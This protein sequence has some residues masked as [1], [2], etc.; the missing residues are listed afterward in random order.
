M[1]AIKVLNFSL[2]CGYTLFLIYASG[3]DD[4]RIHLKFVDPVKKI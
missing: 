4:S 3:D 1:L 2:F